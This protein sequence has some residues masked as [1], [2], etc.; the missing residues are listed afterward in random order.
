ML[1][2]RG[3]S[4]TKQGNYKSKQLQ[5]ALRCQVRKSLRPNPDNLLPLIIASVTAV[6]LRC[7][8]C[9]PTCRCSHLSCC[10]CSRHC[11]LSCSACALFA[12]GF[13]LLLGK[14]DICKLQSLNIRPINSHKQQS[15]K[16]MLTLFP[17][18]IFHML[19]DLFLQLICRD[20]V[21]LTNSISH[22]LDKLVKL[23]WTRS[24]FPPQYNKL[25]AKQANNSHAA[26]PYLHKTLV[27]FQI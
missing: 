6:L 8:C 20:G 18:G 12:A 23:L 26:K 17:L 7:S 10:S 27:I 9:R 3:R 21:C 4:S 5:S 14:L 1:G 22:V 16:Q 24:K 2:P 11:W 19:P 25:Y 15:T 13:L